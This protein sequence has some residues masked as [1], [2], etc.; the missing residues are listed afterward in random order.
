MQGKQ[1]NNLN[2][3]GG[4]DSTTRRRSENT[5]LS[6]AVSRTLTFIDGALDR[7]SLPLGR[8]RIAFGRG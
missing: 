1:I 3:G 7:G 4:N 2:A 8:Y 6:R 5:L